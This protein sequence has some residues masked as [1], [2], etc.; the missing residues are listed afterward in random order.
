MTNNALFFFNIDATLKTIPPTFNV[1]NLSASTC[2]A[3][4]CFVWC[5]A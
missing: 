4:I 5:M 3:V 1:T 2:S